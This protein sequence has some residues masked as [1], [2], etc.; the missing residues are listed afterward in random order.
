MTHKKKTAI[1]KEQT[2]VCADNLQQLPASRH[3]LSVQYDSGIVV[4]IHPKLPATSC[5]KKIA[6]TW[7]NNLSSNILAI[8]LKFSNLANYEQQL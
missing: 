4:W 7:W 5:N 3:C 2:D 8:P 6:V 1:W